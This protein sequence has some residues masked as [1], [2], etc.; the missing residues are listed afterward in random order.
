MTRITVAVQPRP[1]EAVIE[2]GLFPRAGELLREV[3]PDRKRCFVVTVASV[4][5]KWGRQL[6]AALASADWDARFVVMPDGER[7]KT[8]ATVE[9]LAEKLTRAGADRNAVVVAFGGG[10]V[11]DVAGF[12]ASVYMRGVDVVQVPTTVVAQV[13]ASVGGKTGVNLKAG[14]NLV[15]TFHQPALVLIDPQVL[16]TLPE[17]EFRSGL[18][19]ALKCGVIGKPELFSRMES[20]R[21]KILARDPAELEFLITESVRLKAGVVM[22]DERESGLRRVLNFGHTIGHALESATH[23]S[24]FLH[25]EA[26]AWGMVAASVIA[27]AIK[28]TDR[29]TAQRI[30]SATVALGSLPRV[31]ANP[32]T[33]LRALQSDKKTRNGVVHF[34]LPREIGKVEVVNDVPEAVVLEAIRQLQVLSR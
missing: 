22:A 19:E 21:D 27:A 18:Y 10:V 17:R 26:V 4:R 5:R 23:Y 32:K 16:S 30:S 29:P 34:I 9:A 25:G 11:G 3:F 15:G 28:K 6:A 14:K 31:T 13:D 2:N 1:Y 24:R 33:I 12:L 8:A 20:N 7:Y